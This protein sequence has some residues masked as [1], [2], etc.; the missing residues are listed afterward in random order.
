MLGLM[1]ISYSIPLMFTEVT[2]VVRLGVP[3][4]SGLAVC[5]CVCVCMCLRGRMEVNI[6]MLCFPVS[7]QFMV[8][9]VIAIVLDK[10]CTLKIVSVR[11][12]IRQKKKE[13]ELSLFC[14]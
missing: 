3:L 11:C 8:A 12:C 6:L 7:F 10:H 2:P 4:W 9:G 14:R 1:V 5:V 13:E